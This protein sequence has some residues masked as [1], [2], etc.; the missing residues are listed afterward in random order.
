MRIGVD[1]GG[2]KIEA[3]ALGPNG[4]ELVRERIASPQG[5]YRNTLASVKNLVNTVETRATRIKKPERLGYGLIFLAGIINDVVQ[6]FP[7]GISSINY[8]LLCAIAAFIR[9]RTLMP[10]LLYD[11]IFYLVAILIVNSV[12]Y[13]ILTLIFGYPIKYGTL[14]FSAFI[15]FLI[16]PI[17]SKFFDKITL[18]DLKE[19]NA[20]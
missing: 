19:E 14:M 4:T 8:L 12:N 6:N 13:T 16:Y 18:I 7:I 17:L 11:W 20:K 10:S 1:I 9:V 15:T 3:I 2:T 5:N